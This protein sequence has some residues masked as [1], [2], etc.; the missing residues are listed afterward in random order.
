MF[1]P[2]WMHNNALA[3]PEYFT[4]IKWTYMYDHS[5]LAK[6]LEKCKFELERRGHRVAY[7]IYKQDFIISNK[8]YFQKSDLFSTRAGDSIYDFVISNPPYYKINKDSPQS[9]AMMEL[10]SG[11]PNIYALFIMKITLI[12]YC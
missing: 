5:P 2:R 6:T 1:R 4:P 12:G 10:I 8:Q 11:Q 9:S 7:S 3:D